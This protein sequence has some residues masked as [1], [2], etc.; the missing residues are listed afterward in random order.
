MSRKAPG[1]KS[2]IALVAVVCVAT[3]ARADSF[4]IARALL[5]GNEGGAPAPAPPPADETPTILDVVGAATPITLP[6]LLQ[7]AVRQAPALQRAQIDIEIAQAQVEAAWGVQDWNLDAKATATLSADDKGGGLS[8]DLTKLVFPSGGTIDLH[9]DVGY[10]YGPVTVMGVTSNVSDYTDNLSATITEPLMQGRGRGIVLSEQARAAIARDSAT[11]SRQSAAITEVRDVVQAYWELVYAQRDLEIRH[12]SLELARE[13]LRRT[14]AGISGGGLAKTEALA[15]EQ[16]IASRE[17]EV[18]ASELGLVDQSIELRRLVGM[19][20]GP[21]NLA[22]STQSDLGLPGKSWS[23]D[24][25]VDEAYRTSPELALIAEQGKDATIQVEVTENGVLP[26]LDAA[27]T[28][29]TGGNDDTAGG[30][31]SQTAKLDNYAAIATLTYRKPLGNHAATGAARQARA[32]RQ[33]IAIDDAD[34]RSQIAQALTESVL[35]AESAKK[36]IDLAATEIDLAQQNIVAE[37]ARFQ[38]GKSTNF[39]VLQRQNELEQAQLRQ[40]R[41]IIDWHKAATVIAAISGE[42]LGDY[43]ITV[44]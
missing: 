1:V 24:Q 15:V 8:A 2:S 11:L 22:L 35:L 42:L 27:L 14:Q 6:D 34:T 25:L 33:K 29:G 41:A 36:R 3:P 17:E 28:L 44:Q 37:Q 20:I 9:A 13:R 23:L 31:L 21:K 7:L 16:V 12:S 4:H 38:L 30:A 43:G 5:A 18:L 10:G 26:T 32:E 40:A 19:E 39:D